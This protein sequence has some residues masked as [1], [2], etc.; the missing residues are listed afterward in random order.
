M[1]ENVSQKY[2]ALCDDQKALIASNTGTYGSSYDKGTL[3]YTLLRSPGYTAH[4]VEERRVMPTDR[5]MPYIEQGERD[6][7]F[8]FDGG[9]KEEMLK[10]A[11]RTAQH[12]NTKPMALSFYP[13]GEG[14]KISN[15]LSLSDDCVCITAFKQS[16]D[17]KGYIVRL[18]NP[19]EQN[20]A[21]VLSYKEQKAEISFTPFEN[22]TCIN[23]LLLS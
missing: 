6:F 13:G 16:D 3:Y 18:F 15:V 12:F 4:P 11:A 14:E 5:Y 23:T 7:S 9:E 19:T 2:I 20:R 10:K 17:K 22:F 21:T 8:R 1:L